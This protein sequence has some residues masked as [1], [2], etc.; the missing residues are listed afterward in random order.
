VE[1]HLRLTEKSPAPIGKLFGHIL[2]FMEEV[3]AGLPMSGGQGPS[4]SNN[5]METRDVR[6][7]ILK[8]ERPWPPRATIIGEAERAM[9]GEGGGESVKDMGVEM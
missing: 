9:V 4:S 2:E 6:S 1:Q 8:L 3:L 5:I 7:P